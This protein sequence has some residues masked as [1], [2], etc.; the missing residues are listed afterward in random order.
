MKPSSH[1]LILA[2]FLA[3][4]LLAAVGCATTKQASLPEEADIVESGFLT[5]YT[6]LA[7]GAEDQPLLRYRNP[8]A[9]F[10]KYDKLIFDRVHVWS[11]EKKSLDPVEAEE[12]QRLADD[13]Y[14]A[15]R[16]KL[17]NDYTLVEE[18][19]E[20]TMEIH[21]A[22]TDVEESD[23]PLDVFTTLAPPAR[24]ISEVVQM[25]TGSQAFV[26]SAMIEIEIDDSLTREILFAAVDRRIG[27]KSM[28]GSLSS[29][30]DVHD[31]FEYW[32][33]RIQTGLGRARRG[34][35]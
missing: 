30:S 12:L 23:V 7:P 22:L 26:G 29:W 13:L 2:S 8:D 20:G 10:S 34:E 11:T 32:A 14:F 18:A 5:D 1:D 31:A 19:E 3:L 33:E 21:I 16:S 4:V 17:E 6:L 15:I 28:Q 25:A 9:D 35:I 24:L 27:R